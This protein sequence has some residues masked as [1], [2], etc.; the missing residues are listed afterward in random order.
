MRTK[1]KVAILGFAPSYK[2]APF[3][4]DSFEIWGLGDLYTMIPRYDRWFELHT[5]EVIEAHSR[6]GQFLDW[7]K[8]CTVPLYMV[9]KFEDIPASIE[10]PREKIIAKYG[11]YFTNSVSWM[12]VMAIEEGF[13]EI[14]IYG[15][16]MATGGEY[17]S[18]R[19]SCEYFIGVASGMGI[20]VYI[21]DTSDL[22]KTPILYGYE[23][24]N[25]LYMKLMAR[26][27]ELTSKL[28][29]IEQEEQATRKHLEEILVAKNRFLGA[30]E[31]T[32]YYIRVWSN[33]G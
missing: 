18:Q 28:A 6:T 19:P 26:K 16:D 30:I 1:D 25:P 3:N 10:Y 15:V 20:K 23:D 24:G 5:R 32:D 22:L 9:K 12:I 27:Q 2:L 31:D 7:L 13:K 4:D 17:E 8:Q 14:H 11:C 33:A 21:P 29:G